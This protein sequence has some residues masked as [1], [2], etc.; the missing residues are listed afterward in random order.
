[1]TDTDLLLAYYGDD[2]TGSTD[3]LEGL[4][5]N[6][7]RAVLFLAPPDSDDLD[8]FDG[9]QAVGVAGRSRS[10]TPDEMD[11]TL[12]SAFESL[13]ALDPPL[14]H[15]KVCSTFDSAPE[16]G[17][18]GHA[19]DLAQDVYDSP[20]VPVSQGSTVPHG[21]YV[22]FGN[23]F[24]V[25]DG[26]PYRID[27]H[28]T[29]SDHPVTPMSESDLRRHLAEQTDRSIGTVDVRSLATVDSAVDSLDEA[30]DNHEIVVF[31]GIT[32]DHLETI[33]RVLWDRATS[34]SDPLFAVGSSGLEH[35]ALSSRWDALGEI[36]RSQSVL[37]PRSP[38]DRIAVMSGSA[39]PVTARQI[40][41]AAETGFTIIDLETARL[42]DPAEAADARAIAV[43]AAV[44]AIDGGQSVVLAAARGPDDA[45]IAETRLRFES[46]DSDETL[47]AVLGREQGE[48]FRRVLEET[49][50]E[51][52]CVAGGDTSGFVVPALDVT[53]L[54]P[55]APTAPG[56]PLCRA[57][58]NDPTFDGLE[59]SLKGGQT[60]DDDY[61]ELVRRGGVPAE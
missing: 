54:E 16:I 42:V 3:A 9:I 50:I 56:A 15:Y 31:D 46:V 6:G 7:V 45:A 41:V 48:I 10:M 39:S 4:A 37:E 40:E 32:T 20:F 8:E 1:M 36:D 57:A 38:V 19:I 59:L 55:I 24:A 30:T 22:A 35:H 13:A 11:E 14:V 33:G 23:L 47:G 25:Q 53:A 58:S 34:E 27:R 49:G 17:S 12:P 21:R 18:I 43:E 29:M 51:R 61:F 5:R 52:A 44:Q 26:T 2:I 60:G 28:P